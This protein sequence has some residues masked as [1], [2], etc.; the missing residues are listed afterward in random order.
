MW[1]LKIAKGGEDP[2][3]YSRNNFVGR[4]IWKFDPEAGSPH[5]RAEVEQARLN[6]YNNRYQ[7]KPRAD[8]LWRMQVPTLLSSHAVKMDLLSYICFTS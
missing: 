7:V 6:F 1:R 5:E 2:Y 3:I 8:L 4:Q